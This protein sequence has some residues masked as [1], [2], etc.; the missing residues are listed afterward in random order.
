MAEG[1][2]MKVFKGP[3]AE[4]YRSALATALLQSWAGTGKEPEDPFEDIA[5]FE[6]L[7]ADFVL[8]L[9]GEVVLGY[10]IGVPVTDDYPSWLMEFGAQIGDYY[11]A[12]GGVVPTA[13]GRGIMSACYEARQKIVGDRV[14]WARTFKDRMEILHLFVKFGLL[15][16]S[17]YN[18]ERVIYGG[19]K[20]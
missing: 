5:F 16:V 7:A 18:E 8:A 3:V 11:Y 12:L 17:D 6:D 20:K 9:E 15:Y 10:V 1:I 4:P 2:E 19:R 14:C 13:R